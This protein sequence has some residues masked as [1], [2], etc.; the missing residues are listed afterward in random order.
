MR[1]YTYAMPLLR[2]H[3][4]PSRAM[5]VIKVLSPPASHLPCRCHL[6]LS[7]SARGASSKLVLETLARRSRPRLADEVCLF[8]VPY[9]LATEGLVAWRSLA[10]A[11][12]A[13]AAYLALSA[14]M[15]CAFQT[16]HVGL[17]S[18]FCSVTA[19]VGWG[20]FVRRGGCLAVP[21]RPSTD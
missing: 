4:M 18:H 7:E 2:L 8:C 19:T 1:K 20:A 15:T 14:C 6:W 9:A 13:A 5:Q 16:A 3:G 21:P 11:R 12:G 10:S 17:N